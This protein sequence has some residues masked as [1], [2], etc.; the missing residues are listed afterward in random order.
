MAK[1][2]TLAGFQAYGRDLRATWNA[3]PFYILCYLGGYFFLFF[4]M[5]VW[6]PGNDFDTMS[7]YIAR[8]KLE[9]FGDLHRTAT[10]ELQYLFPK[11]FDYLHKPFLELGWFTTFSAFAPLCIACLVLFSVFE[12]RERLICLFFVMACPPILMAATSFKNDLPLA[13]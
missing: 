6:V 10:L 4:M 12:R 9:E 2:K 11:F 8:I 3:L 1:I 7:S 13:C 5:M